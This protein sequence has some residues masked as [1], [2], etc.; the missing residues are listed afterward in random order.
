AQHEIVE[1]SKNPKVTLMI[2]D[3]ASQASIISFAEQ[4]NRDY[5]RIDA[6]VNNAGLF[7]RDRKTTPDGLEMQFA[8]NYLGG[9][10]LTHL[11]LDT[12]IASAPSRIVNV[13]SSAHKGATIDFDDLQGER[14]YR[15][16]S[17]YGQSKL[18]QI[19]F[20]IEF[21]RRLADTGVTVNAAHP[22]V[23][24]TN[25]GFDDYPEIFRF[26]RS[27]FKSPAKGAETPIFLTVS[28]AVATLTGQYFVN[29]QV[30]ALAPEAR[31]P[32]IARRLYDV[33][34]KL[35]GLGT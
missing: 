5:R 33:S 31:D 23:V 12:L 26:V 27:F 2:V 4:F 16:Y 35:A 20:T 32:E 14:K 18:A 24:K 21:A 13:T 15:G 30:K 28:P 6:L 10:L 1:V 25:L 29:R 19:L 3:L 7:N 17:A 11:L 8:V 9:F 22:G 34:V